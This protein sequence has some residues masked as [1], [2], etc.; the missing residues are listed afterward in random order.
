MESW[1]T[2][3]SGCTN[4]IGIRMALGAQ[5]RSVLTMILREA[6]LLAVL[7]I[8]L[9]IMV[10]FMATRLIQSELFGIGSNDPL[11][12][13]VAGVL[14]LLIALIAGLMPARRAANIDPCE[15]LRHE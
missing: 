10:S 4:E 1:P 13:S 14:L 3:W 5:A 12:Y 9:G 7:G 2:T 6:W 15:A 11:A 8:A